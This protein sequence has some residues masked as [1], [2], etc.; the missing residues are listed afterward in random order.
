MPIGSV[1]KATQVML[2]IYD[3]LYSKWATSVSSEQSI[4]AFT[5]RTPNFYYPFSD[6]CQTKVLSQNVDTAVSSPLFKVPRQELTGVAR[7][8]SPSPAHQLGN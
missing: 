4:F 1:K 6:S 5:S 8:S 3:D 7:V 2:K